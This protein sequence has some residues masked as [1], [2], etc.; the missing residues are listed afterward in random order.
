M[1]CEGGSMSSGSVDL[2][3]IEIMLT[4]NELFTF[5]AINLLGRQRLYQMHS[6]LM[7]EKI[8]SDLLLQLR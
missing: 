1:T 8:V 3:N 2:A 6:I 7:I 5:W 4:Q